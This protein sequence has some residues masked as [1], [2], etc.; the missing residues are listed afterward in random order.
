[1]TLPDPLAVNATVVV[2]ILIE[3]TLIVKPAPGN[4]YASLL[5][6]ECL[7][8]MKAVAWPLRRTV[9]WAQVPGGVR[10]PGSSSPGW[11]G[12]VQ[13][14]PGDYRPL[15]LEGLVAAVTDRRRPAKF[16]ASSS[17]AVAVE[18]AR[19]TR[20]SGSLS[21]APGRRLSWH[22]ARRDRKITGPAGSFGFCAGS[23]RIWV[24]GVLVFDPL[25]RL[26]RLWMSCLPGV[27]L[28]ER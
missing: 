5:W 18:D 27:P 8:A 6:H 20:H 22:T 10:L 1:M 21:A 2:L 11:F 14:E 16:W 7:M 19:L 13:A 9:V 12:A 24:R 15:G 28:A 4:G 3:P 26:H 23:R 17:S 25:R